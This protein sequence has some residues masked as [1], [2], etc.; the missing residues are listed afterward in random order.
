MYVVSL[1]FT[2]CLRTKPMAHVALLDE[3]EILGQGGFFSLLK[4]ASQ[5]VTAHPRACA[6]YDLRLPHQAGWS[7][8]LLGLA[9]FWSEEHLRLEVW[10]E[11]VEKV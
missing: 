7:C 9:G 5:A 8:L 11:K 10:I 1:N 3:A 2:E 6:G 4:G